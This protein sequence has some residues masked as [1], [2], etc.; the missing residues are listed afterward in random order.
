MNLNLIN[1]KKFFLWS[2]FFLGLIHLLF[3]VYF[4][5]DIPYWDEWEIFSANKFVLNPN[6]TSL[7]QQHNE[8]RLVIPNLFFY[9]YT[10]V[11]K[12]HTATLLTINYIIY[13]SACTFFVKYV[14]NQYP[15]RAYFY[16][17]LLLISPLNFENLFWPFQIQWH[18]NLLFVLLSCIT[19]NKISYQKRDTVYLSILPLLTVFSLGSGSAAVL[20]ISL[21]LVIK[22]LLI[23]KNRSRFMWLYLPF[24]ISSFFSVFMYFTNYIKPESTPKTVWPNTIE[25]WKHLST[26]LSLGM[27]N[28]DKKYVW[29]GIVLILFLLFN[30]F[31]YLQQSQTKNKVTET[32][33]LISLAILSMIA[34][35]SLS[36]SGF[37]FEQGFAGRYF[38]FSVFFT[39]SVLLLFFINVDHLKIKKYL[40][41]LFAVFLFF[42][43]EPLF[44]FQRYY[45]NISNERLRA[46]NCVKEAYLSNQSKVCI[47]A[48][49][50]DIKPFLDTIKNSNLNLNFV[51]KIN[52]LD[53]K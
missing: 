53:S 40:Y 31:K 10:H 43:V 13:F 15:F 33:I 47:D 2:Y 36:R 22:S 45:Q 38:E 48:Y 39:V 1:S 18:L 29:S 7:F 42:K 5:V 26:I 4:S 34:P 32:L 8:H 17:L 21:Y 30:I 49:P 9:I 35:I 41:L 50:V 52:A 28:L 20:S 44:R 3:I 37:G 51:K 11:F 23:E 12:F 14:L 19:L 16:L 46:F 27:G 24:I 6:L 25:Y